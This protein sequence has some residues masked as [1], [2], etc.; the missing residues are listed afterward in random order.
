MQQEPDNC[1]THFSYPAP[2]QGVFDTL[3]QRLDNM[4]GRIEEVLAGI[5][6][7]TD[8]V[9]QDLRSSITRIRACSHRVN[10]PGLRAIIRLEIGKPDVRL[11]CATLP[12]RWVMA[13]NG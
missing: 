6:E 4:L 8:N 7:V 1:N 9:A 2:Q 3:A 10:R 13:W 11:I 5:R 12:D